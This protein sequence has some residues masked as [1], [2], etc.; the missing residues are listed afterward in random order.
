[1]EMQLNFTPTT[2]FIP[3]AL[4]LS[5]AVTG[6]CLGSQGHQTELQRLRTDVNRLESQIRTLEDQDT[7]IKKTLKQL[8]DESGGAAISLLLFGAFCALWAQNTG[9]NSWLWFFLGLFFNIITVLFL[10]SKNSHDI[11]SKRNPL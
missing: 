10:L 8:I 7:E 6:V 1:M 4:M 2:F 11:C 9:R 5:L 3:L